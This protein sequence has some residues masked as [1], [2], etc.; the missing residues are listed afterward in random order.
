M[1][2]SNFSC[3]LYTNIR[4]QLQEL[5]I[6][7]SKQKAADLL[8]T[9]KCAR[10]QMSERKFHIVDTLKQ[11]GFVINASDIYGAVNNL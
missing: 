11:K 3:D 1:F 4:H 9:V 10:L 5:H 2:G 6:K 7:S 8:S